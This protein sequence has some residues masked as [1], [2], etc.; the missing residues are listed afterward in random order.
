MCGPKRQKVHRIID[1]RFTK[2]NNLTACFECHPP[3]FVTRIMSQKYAVDTQA[4]ALL[5]L[6]ALGS[7][8]DST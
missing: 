1:R 4:A 7:T 2:I 5:L 8:Y 3:M 6:E